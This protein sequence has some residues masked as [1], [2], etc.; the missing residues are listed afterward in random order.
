MAQTLLLVLMLP[1]TV[2]AAKEDTEAA[3]A[4]VADTRIVY[5]VAEAL[6]AL[7]ARPQTVA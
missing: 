7:L 2:K 1:I 5:P 6:G 4:A 3:E